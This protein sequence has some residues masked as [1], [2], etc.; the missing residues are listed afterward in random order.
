MALAV[1]ITYVSK[2]GSQL[3]IGFKV[4]ASGNYVAGGD[5]LNFATATQDPLF[6]GLCADVEA[7]GA[8]I[9]FDAWSNSGNIAVNYFPVLGTTQANCKL[10]VITAFNTE[11]SA[12]AYSSVAASVLTDTISGEATFNCL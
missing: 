5:T 10:K 1:S 3:R 2:V 4:A 12:G 7:L 8:P 6:V 9:S 11:A